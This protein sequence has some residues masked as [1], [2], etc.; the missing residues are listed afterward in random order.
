[1]QKIFLRAVALALLQSV[2]AG[3]VIAQTPSTISGVAM[4]GMIGGH[5]DMMVIGVPP[6]VPHIQAGRVRALAALSAERLA[7]LP[8]VLTS[9]E[10]GFAGY[11]VTSW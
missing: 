4:L 1:M 8:S 9:K 5:V 3:G 11:E 2:A 6:A 10:S 7:V